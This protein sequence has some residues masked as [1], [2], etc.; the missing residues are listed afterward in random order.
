MVIGVGRC[1]QNIVRRGSPSVVNVKWRKV[2][3]WGP[4]VL[5]DCADFCD[6]H[7]VVCHLTFLYS[8]KPRRGLLIYL[9]AVRAV[10]SHDVLWSIA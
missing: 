1:L 2:Y 7:I 9:A 4:I 6:V 3:L 5:S 10:L 8:G